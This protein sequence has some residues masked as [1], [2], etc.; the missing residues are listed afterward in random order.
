MHQ[1][2][3]LEV[4]PLISWKVVYCVKNKDVELIIRKTANEFG[5]QLI[6]SDVSHAKSFATIVIIIDIQRIYMEQNPSAL[7]QTII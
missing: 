6:M 4:L 3:T 2:T 1:V 5:F 7:A